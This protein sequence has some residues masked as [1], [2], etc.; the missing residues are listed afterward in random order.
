LLETRRDGN[1]LQFDGAKVKFVEPVD[2]D[3]TGIVGVDIAVSNPPA[4]LAKAHA[5]D[6]PIRG[7]SVWICGVALT[8]VKA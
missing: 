1:A 5:A 2:A 6:I 4:V 8:P 3:G 7:N